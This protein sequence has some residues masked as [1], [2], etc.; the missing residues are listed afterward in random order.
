MLSFHMKTFLLLLTALVLVISA[1][2]E[3]SANQ[4]SQVEQGQ[5]DQ[6]QQDEPR[7]S[8]VEG[9]PVP[10]EAESIPN[11]D[12]GYRIPNMSFAALEAWYEEH[13]PVGQEWIDWAW[14]EHVRG[15]MFTQR[16]YHRPGTTEILAVVLTRDE[17]P[18][19]LIGSDESGPCR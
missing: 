9:I 10:D 14:C 18:G 6:T 16:N 11:I 19:I 5:T 7:F 4:G 2:R 15:E 17:P 8:E 1:C 13:L 3:E 12:G